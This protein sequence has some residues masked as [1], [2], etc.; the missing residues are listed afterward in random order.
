MD[1]VCETC[2]VTVVACPLCG[3]PFD[4]C[5]AHG[6]EDARL[7]ALLRRDRHVDT[8]HLGPR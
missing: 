6:G 4:F 3:H 2:T 7:K 8:V 5:T 1:V